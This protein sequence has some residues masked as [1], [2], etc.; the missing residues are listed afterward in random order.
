[1]SIKRGTKWDQLTAGIAKETSIG[2]NK[3][4]FIGRKRIIIY[5]VH[6]GSK[7]SQ[8]DVPYC[9][10]VNGSIKTKRTRKKASK[11]KR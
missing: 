5:H 2:E 8:S 4:I 1:M 10:R 6:P 3:L 7:Q 11:G 9:S